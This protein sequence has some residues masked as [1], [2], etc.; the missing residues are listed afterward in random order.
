MRTQQIQKECL[1]NYSSKKSTR[2]KL[3]SFDHALAILGVSM[4][5]TTAKKKSSLI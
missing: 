2:Q 3:N 5:K 4:P 1:T